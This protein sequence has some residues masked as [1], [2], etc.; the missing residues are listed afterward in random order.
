[1]GLPDYKINYK[2]NSRTHLIVDK[3]NRSIFYLNQ[4]WILQ[5]WG[6]SHFIL[7]FPTS[8][9]RGLRYLSGPL[10]HFPSTPRTPWRN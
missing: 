4:T 6:S 7:L 5:S 3:C 9:V 10:S 8:Q 2:L 1:M